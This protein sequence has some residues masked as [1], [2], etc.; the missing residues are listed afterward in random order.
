MAQMYG[1]IRTSRQLQEGTPGMA[2]ASQELQ[3]RRAGVP[4]PNIFRDVG[5]SGSTGTRER[6]GWHRLNDRLAGGDTL[7]VVAID[8]IGRLWTDTVRSMVELRDRGVK[9]RSLAETEAQW[10]TYLEADEGSLEAFF[11]QVLTMFAAWVADQELASIKRRTR[12]GLER[13][14]RQGK[15]LGRPPSL[16]P[17]QVAAMRRMRQGGASYRQIAE[18]FQSSATTVRRVLQQEGVT[19]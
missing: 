5:I 14:R 13:A 4:V 19:P 3:L 6:R 8:R 9:I 12:D 11:G 17:Q 15:V 18:A 7:V 1:Y 10:T 16:R 2:P